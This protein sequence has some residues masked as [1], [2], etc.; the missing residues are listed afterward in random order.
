MYTCVYFLTE[1]VQAFKTIRSV[2]KDIFLN[3]LYYNMKMKTD[4]N[5][6]GLCQIE[7]N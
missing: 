3:G 6:F 5:I 4:G 2:D 7:K 1:Y